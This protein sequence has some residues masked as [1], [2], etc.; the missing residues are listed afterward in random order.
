LGLLT[1][2]VIALTAGALVEERRRAFD[3]GMQGFLSKP[4]DPAQLIRVLRSC[5]ETARGAVLPV[6][7]VVCRPVAGAAPWPA[8]AGIDAVEVAQRLGNDVPLFV[9][10]LRQL[11]HEFRDLREVPAAPSEA[12][13][14]ASA[15]TARLH[16][17]R[18]SAGTLGAHELHRLAGAAEASLR[19]GDA[20]AHAAVGRVSLELARLA[21]NSAATLAAPLAPLASPA[22]PAPPPALPAPRSPEAVADGRPASQPETASVQHLIRQLESHDL[23][24]IDSF[25][26]LTPVL[27]SS[28]G[29]PAFATLSAAMDGLDFQQAS[30]LLSTRLPPAVLSHRAEADAITD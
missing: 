3:A 26:G 16:K 10:L 7:G 19:A 22:P 29:E 2:P 8:I 12:A 28:L 25:Q 13:D 4:L 21:A 11:L 5:I 14:Q 23:D 1:L 6:S 18:G 30:S 17:L 20:D 15:L 24:A 9:L 27:R